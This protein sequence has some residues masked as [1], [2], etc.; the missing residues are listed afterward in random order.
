MNPTATQTHT[1]T[2]YHKSVPDSVVHL[3]PTQRLTSMSSV[4]NAETGLFTRCPF[5]LVVQGGVVELDECDV[6][7]LHKREAVRTTVTTGRTTIVF[8][9]LPH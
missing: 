7:R 2:R 6:S 3:E 4:D 8:C 9:V 1:T 5:G